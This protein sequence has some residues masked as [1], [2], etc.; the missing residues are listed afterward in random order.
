MVPRDPDRRPIR[1]RLA[2]ANT[3]DDVLTILGRRRLVGYA[4]GLGAVALAAAVEIAYLVVEV[5]SGS[6]SAWVLSALPAA[7]FLVWFCGFVAYGMA[8]Y[9]TD[10]AGQARIGSE[11]WLRGSTR[12]SSRPGV[13]SSI[14][15]AGEVVDVHWRASSNAA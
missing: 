12:T 3:R 13:R 1:E 9:I 10:D 8:Y 15:R 6:K 5:A 14:T 4:V 11:Q 2:E 7:L